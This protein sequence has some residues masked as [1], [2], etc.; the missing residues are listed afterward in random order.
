VGGSRIWWALPGL[1]INVDKN[2]SQ[3]ASNLATISSRLLGDLPT[4]G[5][6]EAGGLMYYGTKTPD[7]LR[8]ATTYVDTILKGA[9]AADLPVQQPKKLEFI[10]NLKTASQIGLTISHEV[11]ARTDR[12]IR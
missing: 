6:T 1:P 4:N 10:I 7:L 12:V 5:N 2:I 8:R 9:K 11:L 3:W